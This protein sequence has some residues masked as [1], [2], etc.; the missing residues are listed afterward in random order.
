[1]VL[2]I[3][4]EIN[5]FWIHQVRVYSL[6]PPVVYHKD[7]GFS[8]NQSL[9]LPKHFKKL[10]STQKM[11]S[12]F[13]QFQFRT[14]ESCRKRLMFYRLLRQPSTKEGDSNQKTQN[15]TYL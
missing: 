3:D 10:L 13:R 6:D 14:K 15:T 4:R 1:M 12:K 9:K 11:I 8:Y 5:R 7:E 2:P